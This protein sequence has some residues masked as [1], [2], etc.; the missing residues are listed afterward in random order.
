MKKNYLTQIK[1]F[2]KRKLSL[3]D[4]EEDAVINK[5][6][7]SEDT[8]SPIRLGKYVLGIGFFGFMIWAAF[9][10]L[11]EGVPCQGAV[12]IDTKRKVVQHLSGGIVKKIN[13]KEGQH[14]KEGDVLFVLDDSL[15]KARLEEV[16][17]K[18][19]GDRA[20]E[21]RLIAEQQGKSRINFHPDIVAM[22]DNPLAAQHMHNQELLL[23]SRRAVLKAQIQGIDESI[24]GQEAQIQGLR[25][26]LQNREAQLALFNEQLV[27]I[28]D[29]VSEGY[30]PKSQQQDLQLKI[31]QTKSDIAESQSGITKARRA[32]G[33]LKQKAIQSVEESKKEVD[34][35]MA[36]VKLEVDSN[37]DKLKALLEE[38]GRI[39]LKSPVSGQVVGIQ[40]QTVGAIIQAGQKILDVVP[41]SEGLLL[42]AKIPPNLIDKVH[43]GQVA[44]VR[45][46]NFANSPQLMVNGL[47]DSISKDLLTDPGVNPNQ[48]GASYY[49]AR[50]SLGPEAMKELGSRTMQPGMPVQIVIKTGERSLLTYLMHPFMKRISSSMKEE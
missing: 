20:L 34:G 16:R 43:A 15:T 31:S 45:F 30:A 11:D 24:K 13:V 6:P 21:S 35:Q 2:F 38:M 3:V 26:I 25:S 37:A 41:E 27:G 49:L 10:Q 40:V 5:A 50:V 39:E 36:Q 47:V 12:S 46:T 23:D 4:R 7:V 19:I 29:L 48:A 9:A 32:I 1:D 42:E 14:V 33:E 22:R 44:D 28:R 18:Y 8:S 17:Q